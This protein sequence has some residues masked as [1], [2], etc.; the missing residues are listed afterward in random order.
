M[1]AKNLLIVKVDRNIS[2]ERVE[3][4]LKSK[5]LENV[6]VLPKS[7]DVINLHNEGYKIFTKEDFKRYMLSKANASE[8]NKR[9]ISVI[10]EDWDKIRKGYNFIIA[11]GQDNNLM[12]YSVEYFNQKILG[13]E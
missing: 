5:G 12:F 10:N 6:L 1:D 4:V 8:I 11:V 3:N 2:T 9:F 13:A 7:I